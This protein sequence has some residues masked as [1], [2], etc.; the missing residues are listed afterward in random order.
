MLVTRRFVLL[1]LPSRT[2]HKVPASR[3]EEH[4]LRAQ[5]VAATRLPLQKRPEHIQEI[6]DPAVDRQTMIV[7]YVSS[8]QLVHAA[9]QFVEFS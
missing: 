5:I 7:V 3:N 9:S 4:R 8:F 1:A 2:Q 6:R